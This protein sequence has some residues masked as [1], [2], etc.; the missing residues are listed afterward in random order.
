MVSRQREEIRLA[1]VGV[2][3]RSLWSGR[4][5]RTRRYTRLLCHPHWHPSPQP[6]CNLGPPASCPQQTQ[7]STQN[8]VYNLAL[9]TAA[10]QRDGVC[11]HA[12]MITQTMDYR[13]D[14]TCLRIL[15]DAPP[16]QMSKL[17]QFPHED[18]NGAPP[19]Y[20]LCYGPS[21]RPLR[22]SASTKS[23]WLC[24][25]HTARQTASCASHAAPL[26]RPMD[27]SPDG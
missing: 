4:S 19:G 1:G 9:Q 23:H 7:F 27:E 22:H 13:Y 11:K 25:Q 20:P 15:V 5:H 8:W 24:L 3:I 17:L 10:R 12:Y 16:S 26:A 21:S 18:R 2:E 14:L 6:W